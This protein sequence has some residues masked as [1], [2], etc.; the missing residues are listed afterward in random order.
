MIIK[1]I[2][3]RII[4]HYVK[5]EIVPIE[6]Q[7]DSNR[8]LYGK[9]ALIA[10]GS[11]GI[12]FSI[13]RKFLESGC[14][15][16]IAGT[17][18]EKLNHRKQELNSEDAAVLQLDYL[19]PELFEEKVAQAKNIFGKIDI[20][21]SSSGVHTE[22]VDFWNVSPSEYDRV[23]NINLK[24]AFFMCQSLGRYMKENCINGNI[25]LV[26]SSR[27]NEPAWSPYGISKWSL[28]G[29][30]Q[31]L[32]KMMTPLGI[33]VNAIAPGSTATELIGIKEGDSIA[34]EENKL[35]RLIM[36]C[37]VG[38][39]AVL[40]VSESGKMI[41]GEVVHISGGRGLWDIR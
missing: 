32:A 22:R 15:I 35:G 40:L 16:I 6:N 20:F 2:L 17:S 28:N 7:I 37:E 5:K 23:M 29:F 30:T 36:P 39:L 1:S 26:S 19:H 38:T 41:N 34:S 12:G 13:A 14:K 21:V 27:G 11:G 9:V 18:L 33:T 8:T 31:G 3:K 24:G 25:L 4:K 10:G